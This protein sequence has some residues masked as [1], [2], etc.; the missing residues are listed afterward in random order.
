VGHVDEHL[1]IRDAVLVIIDAAEGQVQGRTAVQKL[2]YFAGVAIGRDL[3]HHAHYY[4]PYS[5]PV[6]SALINESFAGDLD[7]TTTTFSS[8]SGPE[9]RQ[10][11]YRLTHQGAE[12]VAEIRETSP[13]T[14]AC[15]DQVVVNLKSLVPGLPQH[16]LSL[17]AKVDYILART[18]GAPRISEIPWL[19]KE[20]G[21]EVSESD[22]KAA[23][24]ILA[25]LGRVAEPHT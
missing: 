25:G 9:I 15:I 20:H 13:C 14:C 7:E 2:A 10:Y 16:P 18:S 17:A 4:G 12:A 21:W 1:E 3:G 11:T 8:W 23:A 5:R 19:A 6:E 22:V 24:D